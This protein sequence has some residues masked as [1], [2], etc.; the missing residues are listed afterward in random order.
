MVTPE[1][2][3]KLAAIFHADVK[4]YS[5]LMGEDEE[6]T[7][8]TLTVYLEVMTAL[9]ATC[10][11]RVVGTEGDAVLAEFASVVDAVRCAVKVQEALKEKN[12]ALPDNRKMEFRIGINLGD[13]LEEGDQIYG[14]GVNIAARIES[15]ADG[16]GISI[17]DTVH[18]QIVDK[19][20]LGYEYQG[21]QAVKNI[22][23]PVKIYRVLLDPESA[24]KKR[25]QKKQPP[26]RWLLASLVFMCV[27]GIVAGKIFMR[28]K[29]THPTLPLVET[30]TQEKMAIPLPEKPS[31][32]VLPFVNMSDDAAQTYFSDGMTDDLITDLSKISGLLVIARNSVFAYKG[33]NV[34]VDQISRELGVR[35]VL[36]GSVR[37]V[38]EHIRINAQLIDAT[39]GGHVWAERYDR[40]LKDI[41]AL[42]DEVTGKIVQA[43]VV[44]LTKDEEK[45]LVRKGTHSIDAYDYTL[46]GADHFLRFTKAD[47]EAARQM[48]K[49]AIELDPKYAKAYSMLGWS[50]WM[51]WV[52]EWSRDPQSL[53]RA[54]ELAQQAL[55]LDES[56][57]SGL[58]LVGKIYLWEKQYDLAIAE[59]KKITVL[60]PNY[61]DGIAGLGEALHFAGNPDEAITMYKKA[62]RLNPIPPVW[63][64]HGLGSAYFLT[65]QYGRAIAALQRVLNRNPN[66]WPAHIYLAASYSEINETEKARAAV[67]EVLRLVPGISLENSKTKL[68]Y[69]DPAVLKRLF[70]A[71]AEAGLN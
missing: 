40:N 63:Y 59:L 15:L 56:L 68:P 45:R 42:Q 52:F 26:R 29:T 54:L 31:I 32:A 6:D 35:Y 39:T 24:G 47:N 1:Y 65:G 49:H 57:S 3:R 38:G 13:V 67:A 69:K 48:F 20:S 25:R 18:D 28:H 17:S 33:R 50:Y 36:E 2:K 70:R 9:I 51:A 27:M 7:L 44:N 23:K 34:K 62:I 12:N 10:R 37:K 5:R 46:R 53:D 4:G 16:G 19:I 30:V 21:E 43:L 61:A 58:A 55:V 41:F 71:L 60:N 14:D 11:G 64:F 66:F 22:K 8:Q